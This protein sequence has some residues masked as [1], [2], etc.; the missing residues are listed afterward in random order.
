MKNW[1]FGPGALPQAP[2]FSEKYVFGPG[3]L[4]Q[5]LFF[6]E[7]MRFWSW[8]VAAGAFFYEKNTFLVLERCRRRLFFCEKMR[9]LVLVVRIPWSID[10][11]CPESTEVNR[12]YIRNPYYI[13]SCFLS[14]VMVPISPVM[15]PI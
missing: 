7:K 12:R 1:V 2:F 11:N 6:S 4:P 10:A 13:F 3:T 14:A 15:A 9:L 8:Y 5:A